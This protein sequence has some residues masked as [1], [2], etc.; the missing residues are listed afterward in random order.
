MLTMDQ[1]KRDVSKLKVFRSWK[2]LTIYRLV[3]IL[4]CLLILLT[5][6][7]VILLLLVDDSKTD[8]LRIW[9]VFIIGGMQFIVFA[10]VMVVCA[11][12]Y[13][14]RLCYQKGYLLN[15]QLKET[16]KR[17]L[18][19]TSIGLSAGLD[20]AWIEIGYKTSLCTLV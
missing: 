3:M 20:G 9:W 4:A 6:T 11:K 14:D 16:E 7:G 5:I 13:S 1:L 17:F 15:L 10:V 18:S 2:P 12:K 8:N 19:G